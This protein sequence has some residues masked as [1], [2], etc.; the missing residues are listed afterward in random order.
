MKLAEKLH[1]ITKAYNGLYNILD[2]KDLAKAGMSLTDYRECQRLMPLLG[3]PGKRAYTLIG[4]AADYF[5]NK[6]YEVS[7]SGIGYQISI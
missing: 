7:K 1:N 4:K 2:D 6:G 5:R 3:E